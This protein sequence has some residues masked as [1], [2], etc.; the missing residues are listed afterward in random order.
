MKSF[1]PDVNVWIALAYSGHAHHSVARAWFDAVESEQI[2]FCRLTQLGFLRLLTNHHV[3]GDEVKSQIEAWRI[4]DRWLED[5][6]IASLPEPPH[7]EP[8]FRRLTQSRRGD[9]STWTDAYLA[10]IAKSAGLVIVTMDKGLGQIADGGA[11]V[12]QA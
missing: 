10:A 5:E 9:T 2:F 4:F 8:V 12:L 6:R 3:M 7:I 11:V 1:F